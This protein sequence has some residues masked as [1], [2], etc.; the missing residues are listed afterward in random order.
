MLGPYADAHV[1][2]LDVEDLVRLEALMEEADTDLLKWVMGQEV[3]PPA[4]DRE[5]LQA[6]IAFRATTAARR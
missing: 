5:L 3:P 6:M 4:I 1:E 2:A